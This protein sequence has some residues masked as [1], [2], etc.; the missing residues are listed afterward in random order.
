MKLIFFIILL[1]SIFSKTAFSK[2]FQQSQLGTMPGAVPANMQKQAAILSSQTQDGSSTMSSL[3]QYNNENR[4]NLL[5]PG[6]VDVRKLL[7]SSGE[8]HPPPY[9]ANLF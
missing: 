2:G 4:N 7:P 9:G 8:E 5:L 1:L 6:E 3:G